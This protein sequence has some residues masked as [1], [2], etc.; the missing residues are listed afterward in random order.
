MNFLQKGLVMSLFMPMSVMAGTTEDGLPTAGFIGIAVVVT[1]VIVGALVYLL[2]CNKSAICEQS[3]LLNDLQ[4]VL[5]NESLGTVLKSQNTNPKLLS[6]LNRVLELAQNKVAVAMA[7]KSHADSRI[8]ELESQIEELNGALA[9]CYAQ[10]SEMSTVSSAN[11]IDGQDLELAANNLEEVVGLLSR[12][13]ASG[14]Q[15]SQKVVSEVSGWTEEVAEASSVIKQLEEDSSNI[16]TVLV[17]IRD[18]AEQTNL[19]ALNAAIEAARAGEHGR[20][21]AVVAD[22]VRILAGKT[23]QATTEIQTIIEELQQRAR[24]AVGVMENGQERVEATQSQAMKVNEAL[25]EIADNLVKLK[26]AQVA[27]SSL[28]HKTH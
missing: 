23:Q 17:L 15:S 27:L 10:Q 5:N 26:E 3:E 1:A 16:G 25:S 28:A 24:N 21:F 20:G 4:D 8:A 11:G 22:E 12:G 9:V 2:W 14:M 13:S 7:E 19:L 6:S 18:I